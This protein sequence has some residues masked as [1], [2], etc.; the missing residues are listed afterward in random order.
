MRL[1]PGD[2][3]L[4]VMLGNRTPPL[5]VDYVEDALQFAVEESDYFGTGCR[6]LA[7]QGYL[8]QE[9]QWRVRT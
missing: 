9:S 6:L 3:A 1:A 7:G 8:L 4:T 2:Y 5:N